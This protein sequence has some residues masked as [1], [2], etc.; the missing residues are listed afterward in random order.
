MS[1]RKKVPFKY[2]KCRQCKKLIKMSL[3]ISHLD[4][5]HGF[6]PTCVVNAH[7][8]YFDEVV[9]E[10]SLKKNTTELSEITLVTKE[11]KCKKCGQLLVK[12]KEYL[13]EHMAQH[14]IQFTRKQL[15]SALA[16]IN[17]ISNRPVAKPVVKG[18]E[19]KPE[20][21]TETEDIMDLKKGFRF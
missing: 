4:K 6:K 2:Y 19:S 17:G 14:G 8:L 3:V 20:Y 16:L 11:F 21:E 1:L 15:A 12:S 13:V 18:Y 5:V 10:H 9:K 7:I